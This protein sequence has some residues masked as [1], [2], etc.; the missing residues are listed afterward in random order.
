MKRFKNILYVLDTAIEK[1]QDVAEKVRHLAALN[2]ARV[3]IVRIVGE[4]FVESFGKSLSPRF[5]KLCDI[6]FS[7]FE[8]ELKL[9]IKSNLWDDIDISYHILKGR[10]FLEIIRHVIS[11]DHDLVVKGGN[12]NE[13]TDQLAMRLFRKCPCPVWIIQQSASSKFKRVLAA[14][15]ATNKHEENIRLNTKIVELASSLAE[16]EQGEA[17][18]VHS[19]FLDFEDMLRS[20]RF[21]IPREEIQ[22]AKNE[23]QQLS[24][25]AI[26]KII[27]SAG[28]DPHQANT[29][30][31]EGETSDVITRCI[32]EYT[33]DT[34]VMGTVARSGVPGLL[35]GNKA[36]KVLSQVK[37]TV[38]A[39]KPDGFIT[40]VKL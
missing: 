18:Y 37:C 7:Q 40:P 12:S 19:W 36:E 22:D 16:I 9:F 32:N 8:E 30:I 6:E 31:I 23:L 33:I 17:H 25:D 28:I 5:A 2:S 34:L 13:D 20:P 14:L 10:D 26:D 24:E 11:N 4:S 27:G 39:V 38:L 1:E 35:I 15:D 29:H 3:S 21:D